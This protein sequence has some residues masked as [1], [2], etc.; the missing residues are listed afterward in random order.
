MI[1]TKLAVLMA[2]MIM[3]VAG[4]SV[5]AIQAAEATAVNTTRSNIKS[6]HAVQQEANCTG[7][8][9]IEQNLTVEGQDA[10]SGDDFSTNDWSDSLGDVTAID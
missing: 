8:C 1:A 9:T 5:A 10:E 7:E 4:L 3:V 6:L 2:V